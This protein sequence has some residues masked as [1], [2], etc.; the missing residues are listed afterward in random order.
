MISHAR[1][2]LAALLFS[3]CWAS[4]FVAIKLALPHCP[5][6]IL[7]SSR[8]F[9]AGGAFLAL[10]LARGA[11]FP[12]GAAEWRPIILVGLLTNA[13]YLGVTAVALQHISAGMGAV[14]ASANPVALAVVS[15][16]LLG[17][18]L[19]AAK[20]VG[21]VTSYA[22]VVLVMWNRIGSD[23]Q[24]W[25]MALF[26]GVVVFFVSGTI[27]FKRLPPGPDLL[28][29]NGGQL[30]TGGM[31]L[32]IPA[33][34]FESVAR[35]EPTLNLVV[36]QAIL[37]VVV[38]GAAMFL[39]LWLLRHGDATRASAYFFLNPVLGLGMAALVLGERIGSLD[40]LGSVAVALG[41]WAVQRA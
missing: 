2:T 24:P 20:I 38:S 40:L 26:L 9:V 35:V 1:Y 41:I 39:W 29:V 27:L 25:A 32:A 4:G 14:L 30:L 28:V 16:W 6:F 10:A 21:L 11:R 31:A 13:L 15:P 3:L 36:G 33:L 12:R 7:M 37:I 19:T 18:R 17:E 8:F 34:L 5:P 22:G 23:N